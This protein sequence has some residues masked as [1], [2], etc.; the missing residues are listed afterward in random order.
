M[1]RAL[2][3]VMS[4]DMFSRPHMR[5]LIFTGHSTVQ[6]APPNEHFKLFVVRETISVHL[7][8]PMSTFLITHSYYT[9][10]PYCT[11]N[12][13]VRR[14][15]VYPCFWELPDAALNCQCPVN[16]WAR[17]KS[18][19]PCFWELPDA[20]LNCQCTVNNWVRRKPVYPCFWE[21]PDAALNC[22]CTV[23]NWVRK[24]SVYPC[25][26]EAR[27]CVKLQWFG[28]LCLGG[29]PDADVWNQALRPSACLSRCPSVLPL[30]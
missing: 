4:A 28:G 9:C 24:K 14:K 19:Y 2:N 22:Q 5:A 26:W 18:V 17:K 30:L 8:D 23:N 12:N 29:E 13:W 11:V 1:C 6:A 25:F 21:L 7:A 27:R 15:P 3:N 20:A 16:N 10:Q